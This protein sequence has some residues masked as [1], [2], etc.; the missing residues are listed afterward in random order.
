MN[1]LGRREGRTPSDIETAQVM[2]EL[3]EAF[4]SAAA[5]QGETLGYATGEASRLDAMCDRFL[6][7]V[8]SARGRHGMA[9]AMGAYLGELLVRNGAGRWRYGSGDRK[10]V[11]VL[12]NGLVCHPHDEVANRLELGAQFDLGCYF[13]YAL[14]GR[15]PDALAG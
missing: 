4:R 11:V 9:M 13:G 7:T 5:E 8:P 15:D 14:A 6:A 12:R 2:R 3:A 10:A 1:F